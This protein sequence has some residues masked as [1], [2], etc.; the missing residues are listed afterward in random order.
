MSMFREEAEKIL[1]KYGIG[2]NDLFD[3]LDALHKKEMA[4]V[5]GEDD[6]PQH[7]SDGTFRDYCDTCD[8][9]IGDDSDY[10]KQCICEHNNELRAE[11]RRRAGL[12]DEEVK[13]G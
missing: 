11:Q 12:T 6:R 5:I 9:I 10:D 8:R 13:N 2:W 7:I 3:D 4:R 1:H